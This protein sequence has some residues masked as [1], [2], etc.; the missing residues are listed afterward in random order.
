MVIRL[1]SY[2]ES[3]YCPGGSRKINM[4]DEIKKLD[5]FHLISKTIFN[6]FI[7]GK[8]LAHQQRQLLS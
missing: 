6:L 4:V 7:V 3:E 2:I 1:R 5:K 8:C